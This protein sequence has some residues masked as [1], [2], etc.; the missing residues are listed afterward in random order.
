MEPELKKEVITLSK[1]IE[2]MDYFQIL[3]IGQKAF[4]EEI[5]RAYFTQSRIFHP[6][7]YYNEDPQLLAQVNTIFKRVNEGYKVL[8][9]QKKRVAYTKAI[10]GPDRKN[11]LRFVAAQLEQS[12]TGTPADEGQTPMGRKYYQMAKTSINNKDFNAAKINLQLA[13]KMEPMNQT[14]KAKLVEVEETIKLKKKKP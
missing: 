4:T 1:I 2:E 9:D 6:D 5:K 13:A 10:N 12:T 3:K 8:S 14:F 7:K 11:N